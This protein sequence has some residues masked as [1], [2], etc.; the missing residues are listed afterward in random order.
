[1]SN[2]QP[3]AAGTPAPTDGEQPTAE[4]RT[5]TQEDRQVQGGEPDWKQ[6]YLKAK[7]KIERVN[8]VE[9]QL[10]AREAENAALRSR[11]A[12]SPAA[13]GEEDDESYVDEASFNNYAT[14]GDPV[15][16]KTKRLERKL[17]KTEKRLDEIVPN[18]V[19]SNMLRDMPL[20]KRQRVYDHFQANRQRFG[21]PR[22]A[23]ADL[24]ATELRQETKGL[25]ERLK[26]YETERKID[27]DVVRAV[28]THQREVPAS[29]QKVKTM[30]TDEFDT[31]YERIKREQGPHSAMLFKQELL[32]DKIQ[33]K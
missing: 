11:L 25:R 4:T 9:A 1:M 14:Q 5:E 33:L 13:Q 28:P 30:T 8:V 12:P 3:E 2:E 29:E 10:A 19:H 26:Q 22:V 27:P 15:A 23:E 17:A 24:D 31:E 21:D 18:I 32:D 16:R 6:E 7:S 20:E